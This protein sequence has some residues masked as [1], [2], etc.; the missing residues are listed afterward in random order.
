[1]LLPLSVPIFLF[2]EPLMGFFTN[3]PAVISIGV[4]YLRID[5]F[6]LY[7]YVIIFVSTSALQGMKLPMFA[8]W[9]GISRQVIAPGLLFYFFITVM[10][11][12]TISL[13][14]SIAGIVWVAAGIA[15][16]FARKTILKV[17]AE[18]AS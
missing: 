11:Y 13:W 15:F 4:E 3:D 10:N 17:E 9:M 1:M 6:V 14:L 16:W 8:I 18:S 5:A 7:A 12:G 2:A